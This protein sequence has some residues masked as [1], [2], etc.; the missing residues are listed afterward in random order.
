MAICRTPDRQ[1]WSD[2]DCLLSEVRHVGWTAP[3]AATTYGLSAHQ[4]AGWEICWL[5][6]GTVDWWAGTDAHHVPAGSVYVTRPGEMHGGLHDSLTPCDLFW[7]ELIPPKNGR[8]P[9]LAAATTADLERDL[10]T[11]PHRVFTGDVGLTTLW[12]DLLALHQPPP[13]D[14]A[15]DP[16]RVLAARATVHLI[17]ARVMQCS[18]RHAAQVVTPSEAIM[19]ALQLAATTQTT[20]VAALAREAGLSPSRFHARFLAEVGEPP[21]DWLRRRRIER[22]KFR[23]ATTDQAITTLALDLDFPSSQHFATVFKR[24]VG[25]T[26]RHYRA[27]AQTSAT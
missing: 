12:K 24:L 3:R 25:M 26:P 13:A 17:L 7:L 21:A 20:G 27:T 10:S 4:H 14:T 16:H 23:L 9:G 22:A 19:R 8:W 15:T 1:T 2:A 5:R 18:R 6:R 11:L